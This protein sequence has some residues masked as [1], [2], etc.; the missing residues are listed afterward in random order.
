M[1]LPLLRLQSATNR[2]LLLRNERLGFGAASVKPLTQGAFAQRAC[3]T[4]AP[5]RGGGCEHAAQVSD[6]YSYALL[7]CLMIEQALEGVGSTLYVGNAA[8]AEVKRVP[9]AE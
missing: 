5:C 8:A 4:L 3:A 7:Y 1:P 9:E 2:L 6:S